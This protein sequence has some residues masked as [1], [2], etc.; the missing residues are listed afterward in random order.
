MSHY[1]EMKVSFDMACHVFITGE[2][3][4]GKSTLLKKVIC[5][6]TG[7]IGGFLTFR[8]KEFL[9]HKYSVHICRVGKDKYPDSNNLLFVCG[10][11]EK[12]TSE[13]FNRLGCE[14]LEQDDF[15]IIIMD[16]LGIHEEK[17]IRFRKK[18][19]E[20]LDGDVP[21]LGVLQKGAESLWE[22]I[23]KH[24]HVL[25]IEIDEQNRDDITVIDDIYDTLYNLR[26][27]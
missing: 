13:R 10:Y 16:E 21:I 7:E 8:T 11:F 22:G 14:I 3:H 18:V 24:P 5:R 26:S 25:L 27:D 2:K 20:M 6:C 19:I 9:K 1:L 15:D 4:I 23:V 17:A 12:R